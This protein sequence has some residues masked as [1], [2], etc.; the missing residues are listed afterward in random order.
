LPGYSLPVDAMDRH[1]PNQLDDDDDDIAMTIVNFDDALALTLILVQQGH[2]C[3]QGPR[4]GSTRG[5]MKARERN[6]RL[7]HESILRDYLGP[8]PV[9]DEALI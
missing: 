3:Q 5:R 4:R 6:I 1:R 2:S 9:Y 8:A 7:G